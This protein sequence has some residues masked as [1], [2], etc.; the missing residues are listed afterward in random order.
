MRV[1]YAE[2]SRRNRT[3]YRLYVLEF[4]TIGSPDRGLRI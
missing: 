1:N 2:F 4:R 3:K